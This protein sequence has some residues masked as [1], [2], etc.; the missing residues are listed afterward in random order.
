MGHHPSLLRSVFD[1]FQGTKSFSSICCVV[2]KGA[3]DVVSRE[4][5]AASTRAACR[6]QL[7]AGIAAK[8]WPILLSF[9]QSRSLVTVVPFDCLSRNLG[10]LFFLPRLQLLHR[11][12][13][14]HKNASQVSTYWFT[15]AVLHFL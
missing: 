10:N 12:K 4:K 9:F 15:V 3:A 2:W 7:C 8:P 14:P 5:K 6:S 13:L 1:H 11:K